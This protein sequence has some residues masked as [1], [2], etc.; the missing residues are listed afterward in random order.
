MNKDETSIRYREFINQLETAKASLNTIQGAN[1]QVE[2]FRKSLTG[3]I[4]QMISQSEA[5]A[6]VVLD[7]IPWDRLVIAFFGETN[8]GKST[9]IETARILFSKNRKSGNDGIIVGD[10]QG[11]FTKDYNHYDLEICGRPFTLIDVP[12]IEG[13]EKEYT[14]GI[15]EALKYAHIVFY[16]QEGGKKPDEA[17][18]KNIKT[19]LS[20]WVDVYVLQ[21]VRGGVS[22]YDMEEDRINLYEGTQ[23]QEV[24]KVRE[25]IRKVFKGLLGRNF[26][27]VVTLQGLLALCSKAS[28][29]P[30]RSNDLGKTQKKLLNYF[31]SGDTMFEFSQYK[32]II[33]LIE[34]KSA[35][36]TDE[37]AKS[38][39]MKIASLAIRTKSSIDEVLKLNSTELEALESKLSQF[40]RVTCK[41]VWIMHRSSLA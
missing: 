5:D 22:S 17:V 33:S 15:K 32:S 26:K 34:E 9:I 18:A 37:I 31:S 25:Q 3:K 28:F 27:D 39:M 29:S 21:N 35:N 8:A 36:F 38:T 12:G 4:Q 20:E 19:Y 14:D 24:I 16:V 30:K 41:S 23:G 11:D 1:K 6:H 10:G 13:N 7:E 2:D 40:K